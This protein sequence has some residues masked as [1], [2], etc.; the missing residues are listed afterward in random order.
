MTSA[1]QGFSGGT[2]VPAAENGAYTGQSDDQKVNASVD[3]VGRVTG[4][5]IASEAF[6]E[7]HPQLIGRNIVVAVA[8]A[9]TAVRTAGEQ[10][11]KAARP[12]PR[13]RPGCCR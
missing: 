8:R 10:V 7:A 9:R 12:V 1:D 5:E 13:D 4:L 3:A 6:R 2:G 11:V